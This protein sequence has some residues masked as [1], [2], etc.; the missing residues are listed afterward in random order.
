MKRNILI[1]ILGGLLPAVFLF[2]PT[3]ALFITACAA[4]TQEARQ[5]PVLTDL[6]S[7]PKFNIPETRKA[8][9]VD[10]TTVITIPE[11][12]DTYNQE[13]AGGARVSSGGS[14]SG[15]MRKV[16]Q[17]FAGTMGEDI[18]TQLVAKGMTTK[19]PFPLSEITY[20]D[21]KGADLTVSI[22]VVLD[23][24]S[25]NPKYLGWSNY[26]GGERG[27]V[28]TADM[29]VGVKVFYYM[30]EP[31]SGEKMWIKTLDLGVQSY[32][33]EYAIAQESYVAGNDGCGGRVYAYRD[34]NKQ[35][36]DTRAKIFSDVLKEAYPKIMKSAWTYLDVNEML[37]LKLKSQEIRE[38]K[39]Y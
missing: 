2:Y 27:K 39:R 13:Y 18:E 34:T 20:P 19:G 24:Q 15:D 35:L 10:L 9:S 16:F 14:M 37:N 3:S 4:P 25:N 7:F 28:Y 26:E 33:Y 5:K 31:L 36:Y 38:R 1:G 22:N 17:S 8:G 30:L 21:K 23:I 12:K 29:S 32:P 6:Y 11:Y